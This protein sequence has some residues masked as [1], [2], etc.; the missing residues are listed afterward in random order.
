MKTLTLDRRTATKAILDC[1]KTQQIPLEPVP[2]ATYIARAAVTFIGK[3]DAVWV[4]MSHKHYDQHKVPACKIIY[5]R[6]RELLL[7]IPRL[8]ELLKEH[9]VDPKL[10]YPGYQAALN[11]WQVVRHVDDF[12]EDSVSNKGEEPSGSQ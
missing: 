6:A 12:T 8:E 5:N 7:N 2:R 4:N 1:I 10:T 3:Y 9:Y 11:D